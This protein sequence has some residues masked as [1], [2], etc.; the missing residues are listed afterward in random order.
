MHFL[1]YFSFLEIK[2]IRHNSSIVVQR[3]GV[4]DGHLKPILQWIHSI[5]S[6]YFQLPFP[7]EHFTLLQSDLLFILITPAA[8]EI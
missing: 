3:V 7:D 4:A 5:E 6:W 1:I 2:G 8:N